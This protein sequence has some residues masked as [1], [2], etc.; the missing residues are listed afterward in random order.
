MKKRLVAA[1]A[2]AVSGCATFTNA[3]PN[4]AVPDLAKGIWVVKSSS[5]MGIMT[6]SQVMLWCQANPK[7][8]CT[9]AEGDVGA[10]KTGGEVK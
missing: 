7:P 10:E 3:S 5:F 6:S 8:V 4:N 1:V 9:K 2:L